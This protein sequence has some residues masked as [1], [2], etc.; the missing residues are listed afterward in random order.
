[1]DTGANS[2]SHFC[3]ASV[4]TVLQLHSLLPTERGGPLM[5]NVSPQTQGSSLDPASRSVPAGTRV[6]GRG[7][8]QL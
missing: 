7:H 5:E 2:T 6:A 4:C 3:C 1:M 8:T